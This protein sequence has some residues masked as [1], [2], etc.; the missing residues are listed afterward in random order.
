M[1]YMAKECTKK[2]HFIY[3]GIFMF[4]LGAFLCGKAFFMHKFFL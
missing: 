3:A 4:L 1:T 2:N